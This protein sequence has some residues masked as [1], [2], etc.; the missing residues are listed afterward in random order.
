MLTSSQFFS[1]LIALWASLADMVFWLW[2]LRYALTI[3]MLVSSQSSLRSQFAVGACGVN[4]ICKI[5]VAGTGLWRGTMKRL[6]IARITKMTPTVKK[7]FINPV[8]IIIT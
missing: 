3:V 8:I 7:L 1:W 5:N 6:M 2:P 4:G